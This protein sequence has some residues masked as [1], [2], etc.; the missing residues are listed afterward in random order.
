M[1]ER[2]ILSMAEKDVKKRKEQGKLL[3]NTLEK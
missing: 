1:K 2:K 3:K